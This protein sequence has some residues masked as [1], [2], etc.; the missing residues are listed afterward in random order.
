[1]QSHQFDVLV[2]TVWVHMYS[3]RNTVDIVN[4]WTYLEMLWYNSPA[5]FDPATHRPDQRS[6]PLDQPVPAVH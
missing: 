4:R 3:M 6:S 5:Q 1:M 2:T